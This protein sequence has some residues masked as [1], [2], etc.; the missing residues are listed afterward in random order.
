MASASISLLPARSAVANTAPAVVRG[1][2]VSKSY[3]E[4]AK[5]VWRVLRHLGVPDSL[6]DDAVHD[7]FVVVSRQAACY[8]PTRPLRAWLVGIARRVA[9]DYHKL[10]RRRVRRHNAFGLH[11]TASAPTSA[12]PQAEAA[13]LVRS[14]LESLPEP[15]RVVLVLS[16]L[17]GWTAPEIGAALN[18]NVNT[19]YTR[20]ASAR[21]ALEALAQ[22]VGPVAQEQSSCRS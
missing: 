19:V 9:L 12:I 7:V 8:E 16:E 11:V 21:K 13:Q 6:A 5:F 4:H 14:L 20:L 18:V 2:D 1:L 10:S 15:K 3:R 22:E 17:E